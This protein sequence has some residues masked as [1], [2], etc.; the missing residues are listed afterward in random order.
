MIHLDHV[1]EGF[2]LSIV[3]TILTAIGFFLTI[4]V[5]QLT[6]H[7]DLFEDWRHRWSRR[8]ALA[9]LALSLLWSLSWSETRLWQPWPPDLLTLAALI[10]IMSLWAVSLIRKRRQQTFWQNQIRFSTSQPLHRARQSR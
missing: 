4:L 6:G 5:M 9:V 7:V 10:G 8:S 3:H 1:L 2:D